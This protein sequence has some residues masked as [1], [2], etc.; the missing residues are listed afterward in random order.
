MY[1]TGRLQSKGQFSFGITNALA[2]AIKLDNSK[3]PNPDQR[4][5]TETSKSALRN[6]DYSSKVR[7]VIL[8]L[9]MVFS[10]IAM[11]AAVPAPVAATNGDGDADI[12]INNVS[13]NEEE[14]SVDEELTVTA[15]VE[16]NGGSDGEERLNLSFYDP[17]D[18]EYETYVY[19]EQEDVSLSDGDTESVEFTV[20]PEELDLHEDGE[21]FYNVYVTY[22]DGE[23]YVWGGTVGAGEPDI[24]VTEDSVDV[25]ET[26]IDE[27]E[28]VSVSADLQN[29]GYVSGEEIIEL[30]IDGVGV[31]SQS[32]L[33]A[34]DRIPVDGAES[35]VNFE[36]TFD[37]RGDFD[38]AVNGESG[39]S[40]TVEAIETE[41][42]IIEGTITDEETNEPIADADIN[43]RDAEDLQ[44][45]TINTTTTNEDGEYE[46]YEADW[47]GQELGQVEIQPVADG[48]EVPREETTAVAG[49]TQTVDIALTPD[50]NV[51]I[52]AWL[53][54]GEGSVSVDVGEPVDVYV[55]IENPESEEQD[56]EL[57]L[58][59]D[60]V[61]FYLNDDINPDGIN[62]DGPEVVT[63][64]GDDTV[65][66]TFTLTFPEPVQEAPLTVTSE[67]MAGMLAVNP[68]VETG[69]VEGYVTEYETSEPIT[70]ARIEVRDDETG[71]VLNTVST[72]G[73]GFYTIELPPGEY[74]I[75]TAVDGYLDESF[76]PE[77][78]EDEISIH[79]FELIVDDDAAEKSI[80]GNVYD[81]GTGE[82]VEDDGVAFLFDE[83]EWLEEDA[84][85]HLQDVDVRD[86]AYS[87]PVH[88]D[89]EYVVE[90]HIDGYDP[91]FE[92]VTVEGEDEIVDFNVAEDAPPAVT[93]TG[94]VESNETGEPVTDN[95][96]ILVYDANEFEEEEDEPS[97]LFGTSN[98]D[99]GSYQL[100]IDDPGEYTIQVLSEDYVEDTESVTVAEDD[101]G[102]IVEQDFLLEPPFVLSAEVDQTHVTIGETVTV[103]ASLTNNIDESMEGEFEL[104][105]N[106]TPVAGVDPVPFDISP[107]ETGTVSFTHEFDEEGDFLPGISGE[108][109]SIVTVEA[110][111]A[112]EEE[113]ERLDEGEVTDDGL[114]V[115]FDG[116]TSLNDIVFSNADADGVV[117]VYEYD[118][119]VSYAPSLP[120]D[121]DTL[122]MLEIE[123]P[124]EE[125]DNPAN[126]TVVV[127]DD[128]VE[129]KDDVVVLHL[130][131]GEW[132]IIET[133]VESE[134]G[135]ITATGHATGFS[136]F[137]VAEIPPEPPAPVIELDTEPPIEGQE[138]VFNASASDA[139]HVEI[140]K[141]EWD[142]TGDGVVDNTTSDEKAA[143]AYGERGEYEV[144]LTVTDERGE[145][146][147]ITET[148]TVEED[149]A[150]IRVAP[151]ESIQDALNASTPEDTIILE[152]GIHE[153]DGD[154][155]I[156]T[157]GVTLTG[158]EHGTAVIA[159]EDE[160]AI[161]IDV[162]A[163]D[164]TITE[165][166]MTNFRRAAYISG[167]DNFEFSNNSLYPA[168]DADISAWNAMTVIDSDN[169]VIEDNY[170]E[171]VDRRTIHVWESHDVSIHNNT[172][173]DSVD[174][175]LARAPGAI[176]AR[177]VVNADISENTIHDGGPGIRVTGASRSVDITD[178]ELVGLTRY[179][180]SLSS[181][182][183]SDFNLNDV[184]VERNHISESVDGIRITYVDAGHQPR[185][186]PYHIGIVDNEIVDNER[187]GIRAY[188][189]QVSSISNNTIMNNGGHGV[190]I[191]FLVPLQDGGTEDYRPGMV[192]GFNYDMYTDRAGL[193]GHIAIT[194]NDIINNDGYGLYADPTQGPGFY[195]YVQSYN[196]HNNSFV[197][198]DVRFSN[199]S[200][201]MTDFDL[202]DTWWGH[203]S[204][205]SGVGSGD[206]VS[207]YGPLVS[208]NDY[209]PWITED[210]NIEHHNFEV[211]SNHIYTGSVVTVYLDAENTHSDL[212][213]VHQADLEVGLRIVDTDRVTLGPEGEDNIEQIRLS[214][215]FDGSGQFGMY[216]GDDS[217]TVEISV[218]W[219]HPGI[220]VKNDAYTDLIPGPTGTVEEQWEFDVDA[221]VRTD[222]IVVDNTVY[223]GANDNHVY[224]VD[225]ETGE[226]EW[227]FETG[228]SVQA[229][230]TVTP[231]SLFVAS[232]DGKLYML[233]PEDGEYRGEIDLDGPVEADPVVVGDM[234]FVGTTGND[235]TLY[236]IDI[237]SGL[238]EWE[239]PIG[240][241]AS[242]PAYSDGTLYVG[243]TGEDPGFYA[244]DVS[245]ESMPVED[246]ILWEHDIDRP[247]ITDPA[248]RDGTVFVGTG[249]S[250]NDNESFYALDAETGDVHWD[251]ETHGYVPGSPAVDN[252]AVYIASA[253]GNLTALNADT[254]DVRWMHDAGQLGSSSPVISGGTVYFGT[255]DRDLGGSSQTVYALH[256]HTGEER[257]HVP[258]EGQ[259]HSAPALYDETLYIG[260][261]NVGLVAINEDLEGPFFDVVDVTVEDTLAG[262]TMVVTADIKNLGDE[263]GTQTVELEDFDVF[264]RDE[265]EVEDLG[266]GETTTV[267]LEWDTHDS[268]IGTNEITVKTDDQRQDAEVSVTGT[269]DLE[270][271]DVSLA[272]SSI[273]A[274]DAVEIHMDVVNWGDWEGDK[275]LTVEIEDH[276]T[277]DGTVTV[278]AQE[279]S[280]ST[281][282]YEI[283]D[284]G[285]YDITVNDEHTVT[286]AVQER[287]GITDVSIVSPAPSSSVYANDEIVVEVEGTA[288]GELEITNAEVQLE[289]VDT[290]FQATVDTDPV[291]DVWRATIDLDEH[292]PDDGEYVVRGIVV[293]SIG[294]QNSDTA[295][296][297]VQVDR[298]APSLS[299][300]IEDVDGETATVYVQSDQKLI[301]TPSV[302]VTHPDGSTESVTV[303]DAGSNVWSGEFDLSDSGEY[304]ATVIGED[305]AGNSGSGSTSILATTDLVDLEDN[306]TALVMA[307]TGA[308]IVF[309]TSEDVNEAL[310]VLSANDAYG[311]LSVDQIGGEFLTSALDEDLM[312]V[313]ENADLFLPADD[314]DNAENAEIQYY[315]QDD[316]E[317]I[318]VPTEYN[319]DITSTE[320]TEDDLQGSQW[321]GN[322]AIIGKTGFVGQNAI[323]TEAGFIS[324]D[325][326]LLHEFGD[327]SAINNAYH[328]ATV[329]HFSTYATVG[330]DE[331]PPDITTV[332]PSDGK[333]FSANTDEVTVEFEFDD[334]YSGVNASGVEI[335]ANGIEVTDGE[336]T[337]VTSSNAEAVVD[338][339]YGETYEVEIHVPD[340][341]GNYA[342]E[343]I[344]FNV[345]DDTEP[346]ELVD[347]SPSDGIELDDG[348]EDV[349][350]VFEYEDDASGISPADVTVVVN[351]EDV[352]DHAD[353]TRTST[354]AT[355]TMTVEDGAS[356][357][358]EGTITDRSGNSD[359]FSTTFSVGEPTEPAAFN[360]DDVSITPVEVD[361]GEDFDVE[362]TVEN[363]GDESDNQLLTV[364]VDGDSTD[365]MIELD[366]GQATTE[367]LEL[368]APD[369]TGEY[370]VQIDVA[371]DLYTATVE[372]REQDDDDDTT[373]T[374]PVTD[375][376]AEFKLDIDNITGDVHIGDNLTVDVVVENIGDESD[377]Q[378]I[379]LSINGS[380]AAN[381]SVGLDGGE[382]TII[383]LMY[384]TNTDDIPAVTVTVASEDDDVEYDVDVID[385]KAVLLIDDLTIDDTDVYDNQVVTGNVTILNDG[386]DTAEQEL[387]ME[388]QGEQVT[389]FVDLDG[390]ETRTVAFELSVDDIGT[391]YIT[392]TT[393]NETVEEPIE[394]TAAPEATMKVDFDQL[395][396]SLTETE[397]KE[398]HV[399]VTNDGNAAGEVEVK[400]A[401]AG[402]LV[403]TE[404]VEL[405]PGE[406]TVVAFDVRPDRSLAPV[407][408]LSVE[409]AD[410]TD[411]RD[412]AVER[413]PE[414]NINVVEVTA[415]ATKIEEGHT[416]ELELVV[417]NDGDAAGEE[418]ISVMVNGEQVKTATVILD[419]G[420]E[421][422]ISVSLEFDDPG[423]YDV[424]VADHSLTVDVAEEE[425]DDVDDVDDDDV[426]DDPDDD[427]IPGFGLIAAIMAILGSGYLIKNRNNPE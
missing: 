354:E 420:D 173:V 170:I 172:I 169:A 238:T 48:Y 231:G 15:E 288:V 43:L 362:V 285:E 203:E 221:W 87:L 29:D 421:D 241:M 149:I 305:A 284:P 257:W 338:T 317:W 92:F 97:P 199:F 309:S 94:I 234:I 115:S 70:D 41:D 327:E 339:T 54:D 252:H 422:T 119:V 405:A 314:V 42:P 16:N 152:E 45:L 51:N 281:L 360:I 108:N 102:E 49:A 254:G 146:A 19:P 318:S 341:A 89:G 330:S 312:A 133:T 374:P 129:N 287:P 219:A 264:T 78:V 106:G 407:T 124:E 412:I 183:S 190:S 328:H 182:I 237:D 141:Y 13:V 208:Q 158:P 353:T 224:A 357:T 187:D 58:G 356:Y 161:N 95:V 388:I 180:I 235:A 331:Y 343:T 168:D 323:I 402:E 377:D 21:G 233:N 88:E 71:D 136:A 171:G 157:E 283:D 265:V 325:G 342:E 64:A 59:M 320:I 104:Q 365:T 32:V 50:V 193:P 113:S 364:A 195:W 243:T 296:H 228:D 266:A 189:L 197:G 75:A 114:A 222:P 178:N 371:D 121:A 255:V 200:T 14:L 77:V 376:P 159:G 207:I 268:D 301:G 263:P 103:D 74:E 8:T 319:A 391:H 293:D 40:V 350:I 84:P 313:F 259:V 186:T 25:N 272:H 9:I 334:E 280:T 378:D 399:I 177:D 408:S 201:H 22:D 211:S 425:V 31:D 258:V 135:E 148:I 415:D 396:D 38:V 418:I 26:T 110:D 336:S 229:T 251:R 426:T 139:H 322:D 216:V 36:H 276:E 250:L 116:E 253:S 390:N 143:H 24:S 239:M 223:F 28:T 120:S 375:D 210:V 144:E 4:Y 27:G 46:F 403:G 267:V 162:E 351:G 142:F 6:R 381:E 361:E 62:D 122:A 246:R 423:E 18:D 279:L 125:Q 17:E 185:L 291:G 333:E 227:S 117:D 352:S 384:E 236:A 179:G 329:F 194:H 417:E 416:V 137:A 316:E 300:A 244:L 69:T 215:Q 370:D 214:H 275:T 61:P 307:D 147:I 419:A 240:G 306:K 358:A 101:E 340:E 184:R 164:V 315:N 134:D 153:H 379:V 10:I 261:D 392:V 271:H 23:E 107:G 389:E 44:D 65:V 2:R 11:G 204:G 12:I 382:Y 174:D 409:T 196:A 30:Q 80:I 355:H 289:S 83:E 401:L 163:N 225:G 111:I 380:E 160:R 295:T 67:E 397:T 176:S 311:N 398:V 424:N 256:T 192:T 55:E 98:A 166:E 249:Y 369:S 76:F 387:V 282:V 3:R 34:T 302:S 226:E 213:K 324:E 372:V 414:T 109:A 346:P 130:Q 218:Q 299:A 245:R 191:G 366:S 345:E 321:E 68:D 155:L 273:D 395:P 269:A 140:V 91:E 7:A 82:L 386:I 132:R 99:D 411:Q 294:A 217:E 37:N 242:A 105:V 118:A 165:L 52:N 427:T 290:N 150:D 73:E 277:I 344:T 232:Q 56:V 230:P 406:D 303:N 53:E 128:G 39:D 126:I 367:T 347:V 286:V 151:G 335:Y 167:Y 205:P 383:S 348:T 60:G 400:L 63:V 260:I 298:D 394:V 212:W 86:G 100:E 304:T 181:G 93:Y 393:A 138:T 123:V 368:T 72:D 96:D 156:D 332:A 66:E 292:V 349:T 363:T 413:A 270:V 47:D 278:P 5:T 202:E 145:T 385:T 206:G 248:I 297:T 33:V 127:P 85:E 274:G 262:D 410:A 1:L 20:V 247:V 188:R 404:V 57:E 131:D 35:E 310:A 373:T 326:A 112:E 308:I 81:D 337:T 90:M 175:R 209:E 359:T 198:N 154:L 220:S 79:N